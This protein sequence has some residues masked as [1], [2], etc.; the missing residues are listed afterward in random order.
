MGINWALMSSIS[1]L[2]VR[3]RWVV[4]AVDKAVISLVMKSIMF[5]FWLLVKRYTP[6][7]SYTVLRWPL[8][9]RVEH[10]APEADVKAK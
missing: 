10:F 7:Y 2:S 1:S 6:R 9:S 4:V 3:S 8:S 5:R